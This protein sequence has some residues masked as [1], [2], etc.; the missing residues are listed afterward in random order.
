MVLTT[1]YRVYEEGKVKRLL[2]GTIGEYR[3]SLV[4]KNNYLYLVNERGEKLQIPEEP[5]IDKKE[6]LFH[7]LFF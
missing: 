6:N 5:V 7:S 2:S 4:S 3:S 1:A